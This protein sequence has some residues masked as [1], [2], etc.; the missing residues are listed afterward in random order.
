MK[1]I[2]CGRTQLTGVIGLLTLAVTLTRAADT[3]S[4]QTAS[5]VNI[6]VDPR[7]ELMSLVFRLAGNREYNMARVKSYSDDTDRQFGKFKDHRVVKLASSLRNTRG[8]SYDAVM[9]MAVHLS[10]VNDLKLRLPLQPWLDGLDA[11][12]PEDQIEAFL[13][14][15]REFVRESGFTNFVAQHQQLCRTAEKRMQDLMN[16]QAHLEWF[17]QFFGERPNAQFTVL[18]GM[19]NGGGCYGSRFRAANGAEELYCVLG[20]WQTDAE[21]QPSFNQDVLGTVVHEFGHSFANPIIEAHFKEL[22]AAGETLFAQVKTKMQSQAYG[23]A[24]TMLCE[25]LVRASVVRYELK[26]QGANAAQE[27]IRREKQQGFL[28]MQELADCL[29]EYEANRAQY[30]TLDGFSPRL[31]KFFGEYAANF[32]K[33][34]ADLAA[35]RPKV[36]SINPANGATEVNP[37][38]AQIKVVFDRPM[39]DK[40]WSMVGGGEHF[41]TLDGKPAYDPERTTWSVPVKL[42]PDWDYEFMLNSQTYDA[43]RSDAGVP[44]E[45]IT[46]KFRTGT[47]PAK[48]AK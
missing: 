21:G 11:R 4:P 31:V 18:L 12:W 7:V 10:D 47:A 37:L 48:K 46:V 32:K 43:F 2:T 36:L 14:A 38:L 33:S 34:Q 3:S 13:G 27:A 41:P 16:Q 5:A 24:K 26:Y 19:L 15:L 22:S 35:R 17:N 45:P 9:S 23:S 29:D 20:V 1:I 44:L 8:V 28:W 30:P 25:S 40:M 6:A 42:K 39:Q